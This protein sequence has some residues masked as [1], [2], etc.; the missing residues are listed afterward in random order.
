M[1]HHTRPSTS[2]ELRRMGEGDLPAVMAI[3]RRMF[4]EDAWSEQAM[5][6]ELA[7]QPDQRHYV[8]AEADG[9]V[10]AYA[11]L[12]AAGLEG[13]VQTIAVLPGYQGRGIGA[14]LVGTLLD[15]AARRGCTDVFLE[16]RADNPRARSLYE[17]YGFERVGT[18]RGYY[19]PSNTDALIMR[20]TD[21]TKK[22]GVTAGG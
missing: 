14:A 2:A 19:Q 1:R 8:V 3:E 12:A 17:W 21:V 7:G 4:P 15:E 5:R 22:R 11:G 13:D 10:V 6:S 18:R 9:E 20:L 16:V